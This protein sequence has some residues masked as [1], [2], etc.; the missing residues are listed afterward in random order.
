LWASARFSHFQR[1]TKARARERVGPLSESD[2]GH[3]LLQ[4]GSIPLADTGFASF[5][6]QNYHQPLQNNMKAT[7][8]SLL[9][10]AA[11]TMLTV[12]SFAPSTVVSSA[13]VVD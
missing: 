5:H 4:R 3:S 12:D 11:A 1:D 9:L 8:L 6:H 7:T 13:D 10:A 2:I